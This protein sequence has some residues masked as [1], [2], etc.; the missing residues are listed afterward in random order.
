MKGGHKK[1]NMEKSVKI[2]GIISGTV[3][4]LALLGIMLLYSISPASGKDT[5]T[6]TGNSEL[7][8]TPDLVT[9]NF[10]IETTGETT[11]EAKD[12]NS[13]VFD[14]L[15]TSLVKKGFSR[16]DVKT[17]NYN[18]YEDFDWNSGRQKSLGYKAVHYIKVEL[19]SDNAE[20]IGDVID[21]GVDANASLSYIN[22]E[23]SQE[24]ENQYKAEALKL[25]G[26]DAKLKAEA[27]VTGLDK[28]LGKLVSI[29]T[30]DFYYQ[31]WVAYEARVGG[32]VLSMDAAEEVK[33]QTTNIV[34][35]ER[36]ITG[37]LTVVYK[38]R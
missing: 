29:Q 34:P 2:T 20:Q 8:V 26:E 18:I 27:I 32:E 19:S 1:N 3:I 23:L 38:I 30:Q 5:I 9:V 10:N 7:E 14:A 13:E 28:T 25:A 16:D 12:K 15:L 24:L 36:Q 35:G 21:A 17:I 22:F 4:I 11:K 33:S 37:T 6:V 31:P